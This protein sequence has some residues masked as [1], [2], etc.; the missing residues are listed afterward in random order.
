[1][2]SSPSPDPAAA[3]RLS[4]RAEVIGR[5]SVWT[6]SAYVLVAVTPGL[7]RLSTPAL[8]KAAM[9][10]LYLDY[11]IAAIAAA[12]V[13]LPLSRSALRPAAGL[14]PR[15]LLVAGGAAAVVAPIAS[16]VL[17][18]ETGSLY[19]YLVYLLYLPSGLVIGASV[20]LVGAALEP[21]SPARTTT[22][23]AGLAA[24]GSLGAPL[25]TTSAFLPSTG[26]DPATG[27][28][29]AALGIGS[30]IALAVQS[31][32]SLRK[33]TGPADAG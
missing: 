2:L 9:G 18:G 27:A 7:V 26:G 3:A 22:L 30:L 33:A 16:I 12:S 17:T 19:W 13:F 14:P 29:L 8:S 21:L 20:A 10:V 15:A 11:A 32:E 28:V 24:I 4:A 25:L 31:R 1:M 23:L 5:A 6:A